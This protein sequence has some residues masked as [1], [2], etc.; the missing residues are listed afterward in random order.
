VQLSSADVAEKAS[1]AL[2]SLMNKEP[3][4]ITQK[5]DEA[6]FSKSP[7]TKNLIYMYIVKKTHSESMLEFPNVVECWLFFT[8]L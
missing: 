8:L 6:V 2:R 1:Q 7:W 3:Y 4:P 5:L